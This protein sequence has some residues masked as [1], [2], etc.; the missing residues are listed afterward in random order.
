M[1]RLAA[2]AMLLAGL[3]LPP[4]LLWAVGVPES[5]ERSVALA[6]ATLAVTAALAI[7]EL[8]RRGRP[9]AE[10]REFS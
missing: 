4:V 3:A 5:L 10:R 1:T 8:A 6:A 7:R 2:L 9:A